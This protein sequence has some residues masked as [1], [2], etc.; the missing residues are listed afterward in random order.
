MGVQSEV[1]LK[2]VMEK[3]QLKRYMEAIYHRCLRM[4]ND[5]D[6]AWDALQD[7]FA[8]FYEARKRKD[9]TQPLFYLY[10]SSTNHCINLLKRQ[11]RTLPLMQD[12]ESFTS[13]ERSLPEQRLMVGAVVKALGEDDVTLLVYRH[14]DQM[15]FAEIGALVS[16]TDRGVKKKLDRL[17]RQ[18]RQTLEEQVQ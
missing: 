17:E 4:L 12:L 10:R 7:V 1:R 14:V 2:Q 6:Q 13:P 3:D 18:V 16:M 15:T 11:N 5:P 8:S 9:I